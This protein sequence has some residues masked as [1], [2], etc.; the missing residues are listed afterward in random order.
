MQTF[1]QIEVTER[2]PILT[3]C[4]QSEKIVVL[5]VKMDGA[6]FHPRFSVSPKQT[7]EKEQKRN[8]RTY[9]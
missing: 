6:E 7:V 5:R 2:Q 8:N 4:N 1:P 9:K 3:H